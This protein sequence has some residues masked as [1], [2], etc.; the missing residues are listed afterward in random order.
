MSKN[1]QHSERKQSLDQVLIKKLTIPEFQREYSWK[2][3]QYLDFWNDI[4]NNVKIQNANNNKKYFFGPMI[5]AGNAYEEKFL[6]DGQQR[7][8][9]S[10][11]FLKLLE[12]IKNSYFPNNSEEFFT[13][14]KLNQIT[15]KSYDEDTYSKII[16]SGN[17]DEKISKIENIPEKNERLFS[18]YKVLYDKIYEQIQ[19][20]FFEGI[21]INKK[22]DIKNTEE[23][24][25]NITQKLE[26]LKESKEN[27]NK[28]IKKNKS[29][30]I[31]LREEKKKIEENIKKIKNEINDNKEK[32][33]ELKIE[34][35]KI[36]N[37]IDLEE[38]IVSNIVCFLKKLEKSLLNFQVYVIDADPYDVFEVF[39]S[40]NQRGIEL[41]QTELVRNYCIQH[42][43]ENQEYE[44]EIQSKFFKAFEKCMKNIDKNSNE[45]DD[46]LLHFCRKTFLD[47]FD[48]LNSPKSIFRIIKRNITNKDQTEKFLSELDEFR[49]IYIKLRD[50]TI[51]N[52]TKI[53]E[54]ISGYNALSNEKLLY[55]M[56]I[57]AIQ[58]KIS[59]LEIE[60][61]IKICMVVN[62]RYISVAN[63]EPNELRKIM[64]KIL[65]DFNI[66]VKNNET[67]KI[68]RNFINEFVKV[69]PSSTDII[70]TFKNEP[71]NTKHEKYILK[72]IFQEM[73]NYK[74][75]SVDITSKTWDVEHIIPQSVI[76]KKGSNYKEWIKFFEKKN[77]NYKNKRELEN[78]IN[79]WGNLAYLKYK[80]NRSLKDSTFPIKKDNFED[81]SV[82]LIKTIREPTIL[83]IKK[84]ESVYGA[85]SARYWKIDELEHEESN[86]IIQDEIKKFLK[87]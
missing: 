39:E 51:S 22:E 59:E 65:K 8:I 48:E 63:G 79:R 1:N 29:K 34:I 54:Y 27:I 30:K 76:D 67:I 55:P 64:S 84:R 38:N 71:N 28:N 50:E 19:K 72:T 17:P 46:F 80:D 66:K 57:F 41:T 15:V 21:I 26:L 83:N 18:V 73:E 42:E 4:L 82:I 81:K 32:I 31:S 23:E 10:W 3:N 7:I 68:D 61:L 11:I 13:K 24:N 37:W 43:Y 35:D 62:F 78:T 40:L 75:T 36:D 44:L 6:I 2:G 53:L 25:K 58:N 52:R 14:D 77:I 74:D 85:L 60:K 56:I 70:S 33:K 45:R 20:E 16:T 47:D 5:W 9:T 69:Y 86:K 12:D 87:R 49:T